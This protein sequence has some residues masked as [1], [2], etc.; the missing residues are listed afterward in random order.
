MLPP[1]TPRVQSRSSETGYIEEGDDDGYVHDLPDEEDE[2]KIT[3]EDCWTVIG[4]FFDERGLV[5]QQLDSFDEFLSNT[6]Q[7]L[8]DEAGELTLNQDSQHT[9][10]D[11]D[12]SVR[13]ILL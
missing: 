1:S 5:R 7:E 8:I 12:K 11:Y 6:I 3:H 4:A 13:P 9:G 2:D 10:G